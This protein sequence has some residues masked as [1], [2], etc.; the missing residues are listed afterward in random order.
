MEAIY[1]N[2]IMI[3]SNLVS[4]SL[5]VNFYRNVRNSILCLFNF[6]RTAKLLKLN[7]YGAKGK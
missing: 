1:T 6:D 7:T 4:N 3:N 2:L 5:S